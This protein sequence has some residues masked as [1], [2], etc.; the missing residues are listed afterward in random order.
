MAKS[1]LWRIVM[2]LIFMIILSGAIGIL[3]EMFHGK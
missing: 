2:G 3:S 1:D